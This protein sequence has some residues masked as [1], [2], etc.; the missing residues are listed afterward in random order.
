[1]PSGIFAV[2]SSIR[3]DVSAL[4]AWLRGCALDGA[5]S[6][7]VDAEACFAAHGFT[8]A[9]SRNFASVDVAIDQRKGR[10]FRLSVPLP[11]VI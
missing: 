3:A 2:P 6:W 11:E 7:N 1:M 10:V 8:W 9:A 4:C 5:V